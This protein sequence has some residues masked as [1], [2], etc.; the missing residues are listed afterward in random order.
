MYDTLK[1]IAKVC[2]HRVDMSELYLLERLGIE[3]ILNITEI[4]RVYSGVC[5]YLQENGIIIK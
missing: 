1:Q 3:I 4:R 2:I 5:I